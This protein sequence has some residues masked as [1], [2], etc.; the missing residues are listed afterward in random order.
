MESE[1]REETEKLELSEQPV[2]LEEEPELINLKIG[3]QLP[4]SSDSE[5]SF[6]E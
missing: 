3:Y 5:Y 6:D 1:D 2:P 4:V